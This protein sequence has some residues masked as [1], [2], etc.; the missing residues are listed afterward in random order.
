M[1]TTSEQRTPGP[2]CANG[3]R[4]EAH[5]YG[6]IAVCL[7][8]QSHG[9]MAAV[10]NAR[11]IVR[12]CNAHERLVAALRAAGSYIAELQRADI[13]NGTAPLTTIR[14]ALAAAEKE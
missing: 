9:T 11:F 6:I 2:W 8:P 14:A 10:D 5:N 1:A 3:L 13:V 4:V 7:T 12:A